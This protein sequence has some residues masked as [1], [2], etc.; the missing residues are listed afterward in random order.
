MYIKSSYSDGKIMV[1]RH[2]GKSSSV[3]KLS[4]W[5]KP[6]TCLESEVDHLRMIHFHIRRSTKEKEDIEDN[7]LF[8]SSID[9]VSWR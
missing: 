1:A 8:V 5:R 3:M 2:H 7:F 4:R 6:E 9:E